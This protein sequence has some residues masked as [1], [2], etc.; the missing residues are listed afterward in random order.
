MVTVTFESCGRN[1]VWV[2]ELD[3]F[4][5]LI[6]PRAFHAVSWKME[7][8][9]FVG[10]FSRLLLALMFSYALDSVTRDVPVNK[11]IKARWSFAD[12]YLG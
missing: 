11:I 1:C 8:R 6:L 5:G 2:H 10:I 7:M 3:L 12:S 4:Q 9:I